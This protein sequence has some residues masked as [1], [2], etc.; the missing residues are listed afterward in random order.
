VGSYCV[1]GKYEKVGIVTALS[2]GCFVTITEAL[3]LY[4]LH[5][6]HYISVVDRNRFDADPDPNLHFDA[7]PDSDPDPD[8]NWHKNDA[9]PHA[10][11][12]QVYTSWKIREKLFTFI[13]SNLSFS[14]LINGKVVIILSIFLTPS[15]LTTNLFPS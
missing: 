15:P 5:H 4:Q 12:T 1:P 6:Y 3:K 2:N 14:L 13:H 7:N 9:D 11:C 8:S 10:D